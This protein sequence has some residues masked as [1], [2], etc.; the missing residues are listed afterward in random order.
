[1]FADTEITPP[2]PLHLPTLTQ[3]KTIEMLTAPAQRDNLALQCSPGFQV[4]Q[5]SRD[6]IISQANARR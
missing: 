2:H 1:M 6:N 5:A 3:G 4:Y